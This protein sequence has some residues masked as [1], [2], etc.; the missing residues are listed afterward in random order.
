MEVNILI[1]MFVFLQ[2]CQNE[3]NNT[4]RDV[5]KRMY[6]LW[7]FMIWPIYISLKIYVYE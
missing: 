1:D 7:D 3:Y 6:L 5:Q 4:G 2:I